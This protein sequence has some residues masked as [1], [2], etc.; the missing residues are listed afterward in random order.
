MGLFVGKG[1]VGRYTGLSKLK[2]GG[3][4]QNLGITGLKLKANGVWVVLT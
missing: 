4:P 3:M 2:I 1:K